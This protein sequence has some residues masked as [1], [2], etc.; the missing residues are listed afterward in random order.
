M[1]R[2]IVQDFPTTYRFG[3]FVTDAVIQKMPR[4]TSDVISQIGSNFMGLAEAA[5]FDVEHDI[6]DFRPLDSL[7]EKYVPK[8]IIAGEVILRKVLWISVE[9]LNW[10]IDAV[11][12]DYQPVSVLIISALGED[13]RIIK[14]IKLRDVLPVRF[15]ISDFDA[16]LSEVVMQELVLKYSY[17]S[18]DS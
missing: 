6:Y 3:L 18:L 14:N 2:S 7:V 16:T 8:N 5:G 12:G 13:R 15:S 9:W 10:V 11:N 4:L 1:A 17:I